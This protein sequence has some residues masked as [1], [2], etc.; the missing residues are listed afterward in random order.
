MVSWLLK[1]LTSDTFVFRLL[2]VSILVFISSQSL[3]ASLSGRVVLT[4]KGAD[5]VKVEDTII[6]YEPNQK[7][8]VL[9]LA[10]P[11]KIV[12]KKKSYQPRVS[13]IPVGST[14]QISNYD[15]ILHNAFSPSKPNQF[16]LGLYGRSEGKSHRFDH[17]GVVRIFCNVHFHMVAYALVLDTPFYT[18]ADENGEFEIT[19]IPP[20]SGRLIFWHERTK[21]IVKQISLPVSQAQNVELVISKRRV[22]EHK[23]KSGAS[24]KKKRR[25][26][27]KYN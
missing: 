10:T 11:H 25:S 2:L 4:G 1:G 20:G 15:S 18:R 23:N 12:M 24:Y 6:F 17:T 21:R 22:P 3:A 13:V 9:P 7:V 5:K 16:D 8:S 26:R 19:D 27:R 14:V